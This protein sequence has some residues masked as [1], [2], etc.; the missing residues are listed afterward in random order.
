MAWAHTQRFDNNTLLKSNKIHNIFLISY[1]QFKETSN[2]GDGFSF[3]SIA[4]RP[5]SRGQV[6]LRSKNPRDKPL[7][8]AGFLTKFSDVVTM[9]E[10]FQFIEL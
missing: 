3:Q 4:V 1:I 5:A 9:R 7:V 10:G 2:V 6:S 8:D